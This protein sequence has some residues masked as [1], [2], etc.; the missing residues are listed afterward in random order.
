METDRRWG[1]SISYVYIPLLSPCIASFLGSEMTT[2]LIVY[3]PFHVG[4]VRRK[5]SFRSIYLLLFHL[6]LLLSCWSDSEQ[7]HAANKG[8][9][10]GRCQNDTRPTRIGLKSIYINVNLLSTVKNIFKSSL[11]FVTA[12]TIWSS[13]SIGQQH[14]GAPPYKSYILQKSH[15]HLW[16][17]YFL[18]PK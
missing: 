18:I 2:G 1:R 9:M 16:A 17:K 13:I 5:P 10:A 12:W 6:T 3:L 4:T 8:K 11:L 15:L 7:N 14:P